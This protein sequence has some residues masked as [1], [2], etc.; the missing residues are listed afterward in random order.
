MTEISKDILDEIETDFEQVCKQSNYELLEHN[1]IHISSLWATDES[2]QHNT[3]TLN[4]PNQQD[5]TLTREDVLQQHFGTL[6]PYIEDYTNNTYEVEENHTTHLPALT[7]SYQVSVSNK[8]GPLSYQN[9]VLDNDPLDEEDLDD[10]S[11]NDHH[12][13]NIFPSDLLPNLVKAH[14]S[15]NTMG[16]PVNQKQTH[17]EQEVEQQKTPDIDQINTNQPASKIAEVVD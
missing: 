15:T 3:S 10:S 8:F 17:Q 9:S 13:N 11:S 16:T 14:L 7:N 2:N 12:D 5:L 1:T 4:S 6:R